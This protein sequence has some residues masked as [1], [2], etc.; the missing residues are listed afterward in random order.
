MIENDRITEENLDEDRITPRSSKVDRKGSSKFKKAIFKVSLAALVIVG[1]IGIPKYMLNHVIVPEIS[2]TLKESIEANKNEIC[3]D[4]LLEENINLAD[5]M[6]A[7]ENYLDYSKKLSDLKISDYTE[8]VTKA[9]T[10]EDI[11]NQFDSYYQEYVELSKTI[12]KKILSPDTL[13]LYELVS[14]LKG[15]EIAINSKITNSGYDITADYG[16]LLLKSILLDAS[17]LDQEY[18]DNIT[19]PGETENHRIIYL[20]PIS[21]QKFTIDMSS[22][23]FASDILT[24]IYHS[25]RN[26]RSTFGKSDT[27][28]R[29]DLLKIVNNFKVAQYLTFKNDG[30][31]KNTTNFSDVREAIKVK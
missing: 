18:I 25:Q 9:V 1:A 16:I 6:I 5:R 24:D 14:I 28:I 23:S 11:M 2:I 17:D 22:I 20:D 12:N 15:Y 21:N 7:L 8:V 27:E 30:S 3:F 31:L 13:R 19:I 4:E 29:N 26:V 10:E